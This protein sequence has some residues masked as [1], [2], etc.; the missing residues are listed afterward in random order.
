MLSVNPLRQ[1][2]EF[3]IIKENSASLFESCGILL[4][5]VLQNYFVV[6]LNFGALYLNL[7]PN[8]LL[9][10]SN[11]NMGSPSLHS[12]AIGRMVCSPLMTA[13]R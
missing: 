4:V 3:P 11:G 9:M 13:R 10:S 6:M 12:I 8:T 5:D 2:S 7:K 1:K